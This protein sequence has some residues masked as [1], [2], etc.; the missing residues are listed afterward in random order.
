M[1]HN[2]DAP[3][4]P[5]LTNHHSHFTKET[6]LVIELVHKAKE[7]TSPKRRTSQK[8]C[9]S[10]NKLKLE[11]RSLIENPKRKY[12]IVKSNKTLE[13]HIHATCQSEQKFSVSEKGHSRMIGS[14][15]SNMLQSS[16]CSSWHLDTSILRRW[17]L[18][19]LIVQIVD[20]INNPWRRKVSHRKFGTQLLHWVWST[21]TIIAKGNL[22]ATRASD[23]Y[24]K[25][26]N[27]TWILVK[28]S[29]DI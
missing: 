9:R 23:R 24:Y 19:R 12:L 5:E 22:R 10:W 8:K 27:I 26:G 14:K 28:V 4:A 2:K 20:E 13:G 15:W 17:L 18:A 21:P 7:N 25:T 29:W 3:W 11:V 6:P 16:T 1:A